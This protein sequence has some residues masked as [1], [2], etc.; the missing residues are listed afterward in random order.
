MEQRTALAF[1]LSRSWLLLHLL[2][3]LWLNRRSLIAHLLLLLLWWRLVLLLRH[4]RVLGIDHLVLLRVLLLVGGL[5]G[6][7]RDLMGLIL[8]RLILS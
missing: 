6:G 2:L 8:C 3:C 7:R 1:T 5:G 4:Y